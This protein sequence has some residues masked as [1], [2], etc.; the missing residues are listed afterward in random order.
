MKVAVVPAKDFGTAKQRLARALPVEARSALARAMLEDVLA[1]VAGGG[2]DRI[3][4][5]TPDADA[6][7]LAEGLGATVLV[8]REGAGHTAAV[9]RGLVACR[10]LGA[11]L[12]LTVP[13]D[14]PCLT[15][16]E[17]RAI[18]AACGRPPA[19][20]FVP[21]RS[22]LGTNAACLAPPDAVPL[23]FG[24]P[25]FAD[26]LAAAR[27]RGLEP[28]VLALPGAGLD[29]DGPEDLEALLAHGPET[30]AA[31]AIRAFGHGTATRAPRLEVLGIRG[32]PEMRAGD[33]LGELIVGAAALQ[34]T[35]VATGDILVVSQKVVSKAEGRLVRLAE[36]TPSA[37]ALE[38]GRSLKKDARLVEVILR[39][40]RRIVR[41]DRGI[42]I[43]E[44]RHGQVCANAGV[45]Q[46]NTGAGWASLLPE[47]P[48]ASARALVERIRALAGAEVAVI[49]ADTF[50]R[51]WREGLQNVAIGVAGMRPLRSYL[52]VPDA[53]GYMLQATVIAAADELASAAEL[54]MGKLDGVPVAVIRGYAYTPGAGSARELLRDSSQDLF[55]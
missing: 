18:L 25:S 15:A 32:M 23:R 35:P 44:T 12:M 37:F 8:E 42:L 51:P 10:E 14:L 4:V 53:H 27:A 19:A 29:I 3:L 33:D 40:S 34:G 5:V 22:G 41:M 55:R 48:D 47:D 36:V 39:E 30:R 6:A 43:T 38:V 21:S 16:D 52:G 9:A 28:V 24:E 2:L 20:V 46:S 13:G 50:G 26:H 11:T 31:R 1:A 54:V 45:D 49:V 17:V 7:A